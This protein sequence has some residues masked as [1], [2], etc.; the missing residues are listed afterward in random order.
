MLYQKPEVEVN[1]FDQFQNS[2]VDVSN[3]LSELSSS[4]HIY[5]SLVDRILN[6]SSNS[7]NSEQQKIPVEKSVKPTKKPIKP[8]TKNEGFDKL[9]NNLLKGKLQSCR[10]VKYNPK[11]HIR[12][13]E[14]HY[15]SIYDLGKLSNTKWKEYFSKGKV[16]LDKDRTNLKSI[17]KKILFDKEILNYFSKDTTNT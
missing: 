5:L 6:Q 17:S 7:I 11:K 10:V 4:H 9:K 8:K 2:D 16:Y 3:I 14:T 15:S 13:S 1:H 12:T